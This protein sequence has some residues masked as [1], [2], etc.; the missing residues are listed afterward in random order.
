MTMPSAATRRWWVI[1]GQALTAPIVRGGPFWSRANAERAAEAL[2]AA[3]GVG[4]VALYRYDARGPVLVAQLEATAA[5]RW[6][7]WR[8][9]L[10]P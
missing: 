2:L 7:H 1:E 10:R 8:R 4:R 9:L 5:A 3:D 6:P